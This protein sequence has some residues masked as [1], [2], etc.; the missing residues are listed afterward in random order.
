MRTPHITAVEPVT[1][2]ITAFNLVT[3][4][5]FRQ[6]K[7]TKNYLTSQVQPHFVEIEIVFRIELYCPVSS[8]MRT[9][10]HRSLHENEYV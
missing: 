3:L 1:P 7:D 10:I 5:K 6:L 9:Q 8:L 4:S 2:F